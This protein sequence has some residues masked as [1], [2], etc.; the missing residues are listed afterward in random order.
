[1]AAFP[2][3]TDTGANGTVRLQVVTP[4]T[5]R[6]VLTS[7]CWPPWQGANHLTQP[8]GKLRSVYTFTTKVL[9]HGHC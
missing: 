5:T 9:F 2:G 7:E 8:R 1:M 6:E 3:H 4:G